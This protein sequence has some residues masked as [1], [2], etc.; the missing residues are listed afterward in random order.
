[1]KGHVLHHIRT[2]NTLNDVVRVY[3]CDG[4]HQRRLLRP[5]M[6][7]HSVSIIGLL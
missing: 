1:M 3:T 7:E 4:R 6:N 5:L 2:L